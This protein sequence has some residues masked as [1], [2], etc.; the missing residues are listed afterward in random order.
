MSRTWESGRDEFN[1]LIQTSLKLSLWVG[2]AAALIWVTLS[3]TLMTI[4]YGNEFAEAASVLAF[5]GIVWATTFVDGNYRYGLLASGRQNFEL[6]T[7]AIGAAIA[8]TLIPIGYLKAGLPG[9]AAGLVVAE[10]AIWL[11]SAYCAK[12]L[13]N[14]RGKGGLVAMPL[15]AA[16]GGFAI[17]K[18][19]PVQSI[20]LRLA[21]ALS[22][23]GCLWFVARRSSRE[24]VPTSMPAKPHESVASSLPVESM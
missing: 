13:L 14:V 23:V 9:A 8:L 6:L 18:W 20:N 17:L 11:S 24:V 1:R 10:L 21:I 3:Q 4:V 19:L 5:F 7:A 16:L 12:R 22:L 2:A 15:I